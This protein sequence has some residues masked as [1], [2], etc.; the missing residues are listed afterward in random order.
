[1][2]T[3][4]GRTCAH[5]RD[6]E[7]K[8]LLL[9][10]VGGA[11]EFYDFVVFVFFASTIAKLFFSSSPPDWNRQLQS[12]ALFA[13]GYIVRPLGGVAMAHFGGARGRKQVFTFS[14]FLMAL[15]TLSI[16]KPL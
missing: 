14:L 16:G 9:A 6:S 3:Q 2:L 12:Y 1:M 15:P 11:F 10:S 5:S 7:M 4:A 8:A 13:A